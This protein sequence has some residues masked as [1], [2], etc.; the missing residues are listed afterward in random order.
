[1]S[2]SDQAEAKIK[3]L[4]EQLSAKDEI[5]LQHTRVAEEAVSGWE[6]AESESASLRGLLDAEKEKRLALEDR[7]SQLDGALKECMKQL[8]HV[9]EQQEQRIHETVQMR[10]KEFEESQRN[11]EAK[12]SKLASDLRESEAEKAAM[13]KL[14]QER[15][16]AIKEAKDERNRAEQ[17]VKLI[18]VKL[19][20]AEKDQG[21][22]KYEVHLLSKELQIRNQELEY[23]K[24]ESEAANKQ[25]LENVKRVAKLETECQ[26]L[27]LLVRKKLPGPAAI[28]QMKMEVEALGIQLPSTP[29]TERGRRTP[30]SRRAKNNNSFCNPD[31]V[32]PSWMLGND[33]REQLLALV[34]ENKT[35]REALNKNSVELEFAR[36]QCSQTTSAEEHLE[37]SSTASSC[38][39]LPRTR[40]SFPCGFMSTTF[41]ES[42][43]DPSVASVISED[44]ALENESICAETWA[45]ALFSELSHLRKDKTGSPV[46]PMANSSHDLMDDFVEMEKLA[47]MHPDINNQLSSSPHMVK[48]PS[49]ENPTDA[50]DVTFLSQ[51]K[52][53]QSSCQS[54]GELQNKLSG[55]EN[56]LNIVRLHRLNGRAAL[57]AIEKRVIKAMEGGESCLIDALDEVRAIASDSIRVAEGERTSEESGLSSRPC[58]GL[59]QAEVRDTRTW[60]PSNLSSCLSDEGTISK[61]D[62]ALPSNPTILAKE[63]IKA[64]HK[65]ACFIDS[66]SQLDFDA[67][68]AD[69]NIESN[70]DEVLLARRDI[71]SSEHWKISG[72]NSCVQSIATL[73]NGLLE[74]KVEVMD[75]LVETTSA[76]DWL[77]SH[78]FSKTN[79]GDE[80]SVIQKRTGSGTYSCSSYDVPS[81]CTASDV[82][83][84][85]PYGNPTPIDKL[86]PIKCTSCADIREQF[87]QLKTE[88]DEGDE[89]LKLITNELEALKLQL[90]EMTPSRSS[91]QSELV[92]VSKDRD[93]LMSEISVI[94]SEKCSLESELLH[95]KEKMKELEERTESLEAQ[96]RDEI[97]CREAIEVMYR[98]VAERKPCAAT[99]RMKSLVREETLEE[100]HSAVRMRKEKEIAA[101]AEKLAECQQTIFALG[102]QLKDL[103]LPKNG[104]DESPTSHFSPYRSPVSEHRPYGMSEQAPCMYAQGFINSQVL[105]PISFRQAVGEEHGSLSDDEHSRTATLQHDPSRRQPKALFGRYTDTANASSQWEALLSPDRVQGH[106]IGKG[107][108]S[109][110]FDAIPSS[111]PRAMVPSKGLPLSSPGRSP[112]RFLST[113]RK[114]GRDNNSKSKEDA[115]ST[116][117]HAGGFTRF[118]ARNKAS[119]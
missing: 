116:D 34:E 102:K 61:Q 77:L 45:N 81:Y 14:L 43:K 76:I 95:A 36:M 19:E 60:S 104:G 62:D 32:G 117:K 3:M 57:S 56:E 101:A 42:S 106:L 87:N 39:G 59:E 71:D 83:A 85:I 89:K 53:M 16:K 109:P 31:K 66:L 96:L 93:Y 35:L 100:N 86:N 33:T 2:L 107:L 112:A 48:D 99:D 91:L 44:V 1:M 82:R 38:H 7:V 88:K 11:M 108:S 64:M 23:N 29:H 52:L 8:R 20:S 103:G 92:S 13:S 114:K 25:H 12:M 10:I 46:G 97:R 18:Q 69:Y 75:F 27:R 30:S 115:A 72:V 80:I 67:V 110:D 74:R 21:K 54:C 78:L 84:S 6:K 17:E 4:T 37:N 68:N 90:E 22:W 113:M 49:L 70:S 47:S 94:S 63:L 119:R 9:R 79:L 98:D 41:I 40:H 118:F 50:E 5:V 51:D 58:L 65:V 105:S 28:S 26:R 24:K 111:T 15:A 73:C 55:L